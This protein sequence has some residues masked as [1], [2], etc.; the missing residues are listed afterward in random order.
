MVLGSDL[1]VGLKEVL[2]CGL[3]I[4]EV[5]CSAVEGLGQVVWYTG[6]L[7]PAAGNL[8]L[9]FSPIRA[10]DDVIDPIEPLLVHAGFCAVRDL[11]VGS[12]DCIDRVLMR[13]DVSVGEGRTRIGGRR[14]VRRAA[15]GDKGQPQ[16]L[17]ED[18]DG[19]ACRVSRRRR[20]VLSKG[21]SR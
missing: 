11:R 18:L 1:E 7:V 14:I 3:L 5:I 16:N 9:D 19:L 2:A 10:A 4:R 12:F 13:S 17:R 21:R 8:T 15:A 6:Q 20:T